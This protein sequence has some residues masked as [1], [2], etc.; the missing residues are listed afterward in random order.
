MAIS[1]QYPKT[2]I[3]FG[4]PVTTKKQ[5]GK[6]FYNSAL[7]IQDGNIIFQANKSLLPTYDVFDEYRHFDPAE[8]I[9]VIPF[10]N[11]IM[12]CFFL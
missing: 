1:K 4:I 7:L 10:K 5:Q 11:E 12:F 2:G 3:L 9:Q 6:G 8:E